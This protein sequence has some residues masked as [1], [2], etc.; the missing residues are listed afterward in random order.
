MARDDPRRNQYC[1]VDWAQAS[2]KCTRWCRGDDGPDD[3]PGGQT[4]F[5]DTVC[6]Y[7]DDLVPT[8]SPIVTPS[9]SKSPISRVSRL[10]FLCRGFPTV[11]R[12][13]RWQHLTTNK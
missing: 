8:A 12:K 11:R 3:C 9:P 13:V 7:D 6:Y 1:G 5:A 10:A 4:C 2:S